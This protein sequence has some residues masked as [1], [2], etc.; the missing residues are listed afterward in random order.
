MHMAVPAGEYNGGV[1]F[2][3]RDFR[4]HDFET[5]WS[6]DQLCFARGIAYSRQELNHYIRQPGSFTLVA[7]TPVDDTLVDRATERPADSPANSPELRRDSTILG[8]LVAEARR[9]TGH[10]IT[11]DVLAE[12]RRFGVGS[13]LL[14]AAEERLI[15]GLCRHVYLET[16]VD[17]LAA[18]AFYKRHNYFVV[19]TVPGYYSNGVDAL[20]LEKDLLSARQAG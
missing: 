16:A 5:L 10:L 12:A 8:F 1:N 14:L 17:N 3:L 13:K 6:I 2:E 4:R 18:I 15:T 20:V 11:I 7:H 9:A 19:K